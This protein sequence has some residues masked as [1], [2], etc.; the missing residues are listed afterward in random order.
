MK[1]V[2]IAEFKSAFSSLLK[3]VE[4]G[5]E[6]IIEYGRSHRRV[7]KLVPYTEEKKGKRKLGPLKN[8]GS[9]RLSDDFAMS[10]EE[11]LGA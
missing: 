8:R 7:A 11:L 9:F 10:D 2:S 3:S 4:K 6:I 5:E 1:T